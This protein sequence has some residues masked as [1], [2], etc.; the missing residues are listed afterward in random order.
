VTGL[1]TKLKIIQNTNKTEKNENL[2]FERQK[3]K[4]LGLK[5][6]TAYIKNSGKEEPL[7]RSGAERQARYRNKQKKI[8][9]TMKDVGIPPAD[10]IQ[11]VKNNSWLKV[12]E[13]IYILKKIN[14]LP[15]LVQWILRW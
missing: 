13:S 15:R 3:L 10:V 8:K 2:V 6:T 4:T 12:R 11:F 7:N 5:R 1:G 14:N 9:D